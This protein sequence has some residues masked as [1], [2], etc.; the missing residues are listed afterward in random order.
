MIAFIMML[1]KTL[2][3]IAFLF[4]SSIFV[5][6]VFASILVFCSIYLGHIGVT[7]QTGEKLRKIRLREGLTIDELAA[8]CKVSRE[9]ITLVES[10]TISPS[11]YLFEQ[12]LSALDTTPSEF[13]KEPLREQIVF[14]GEVPEETMWTI[15]Q[16]IIEFEPTDETP[17]HS[18]EEVYYYVMNGIVKFICDNETYRA[19]VGDSVYIKPYMVYKIICIGNN[20]ARLI[21]VLVRHRPLIERKEP[22]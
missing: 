16:S 2:A 20:P 18:D 14:D 15:R 1:L 3:I 17:I 19:S 4:V 12:M 10:D 5:L 9:Y 11:V 8:A 21:S 6:F 22:S 7:M 13:Y